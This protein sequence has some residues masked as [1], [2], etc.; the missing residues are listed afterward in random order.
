MSHVVPD[1]IQKVVQG[2]DPLHIL[3][4][5]NQIRHYTYGT[6]LAKGIVATLENPKALNES[7]NLAT[8]E[9]HTVL[10]LA[11]MIWKKINGDKPFNYVSDAPYD[12]DVQKRVP[13]VSKAKDILGWEAKTS[14]DSALDIVI[15]WI[16]EQVAKGTI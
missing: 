10:E 5:G 2:Q 1:L 16:T 15:P 12:Y 9:G 14:L 11:Q 7:F 4:E 3:G 8:P 6:D 13:D